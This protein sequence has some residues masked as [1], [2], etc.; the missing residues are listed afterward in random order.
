LIARTTRGIRC[1]NW[2]LP[3]KA[4]SLTTSTISTALPASGLSASMLQFIHGIGRIISLR[5]QVV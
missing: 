1:S 4:E 5:A 2:S 3:G